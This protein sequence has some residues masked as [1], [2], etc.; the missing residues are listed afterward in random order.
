M[1]VGKLEPRLRAEIDQAEAV[2]AGDR[3]IPVLVEH[4][5][6]VASSEAAPEQLDVLERHIS[7][8]QRGILARLS[9]LGGGESV[10]QLSLVN[11]IGADLTPS[12][13]KGLAEH[14]D[15]RAIRLNRQQQVTN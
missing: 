9:E 12:Q 11:A 14:S 7:D 13:I 10:Y 8:L 1:K 6:T 3:K 15:V 2:G 5:R 4:T